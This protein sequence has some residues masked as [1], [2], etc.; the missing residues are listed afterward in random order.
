MPRSD[1]I[2]MIVSCHQLKVTKPQVFSSF[3]LYFTYFVFKFVFCFFFPFFLNVRSV[4]ASKKW[5]NHYDG[6]SSLFVFGDNNQERWTQ[7]RTYP[8]NN[9]QFPFWSPL[10]LPFPSCE[11]TDQQPFNDSSI[12]SHI[13]SRPHR[14][15]IIFSI[16]SNIEVQHWSGDYIFAGF[17]NK[18]Q[19]FIHPSERYIPVP[20][21]INFHS[22]EP[23][24]PNICMLQIHF[25]NIASFVAV[26]M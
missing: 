25:N 1:Y 23:H 20:P 6:D 3:F 10:F 24:S 4:Y 19:L 16:K 21:D 8:R 11:W 7:Q 12:P 26:P 15:M 17:S 13:L 5:F 14:I 2:T 22:S 9:I 18:N